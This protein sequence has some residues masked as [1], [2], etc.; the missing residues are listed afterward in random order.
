LI[1]FLPFLLGLLL[2]LG[3]PRLAKVVAEERAP[4]RKR[5][6]L[7]LLG[8]VQEL[9]A[10][11]REPL[12]GNRGVIGRGHADR[13]RIVAAHRRDRDE[14]HPPFGFHD[15]LVA[16]RSDEYARR[17]TW[18]LGQRMLEPSH[19]DVRAAV[20]AVE[21]EGHQRAR[22]GRALRP[23]AGTHANLP[24][25][26]AIGIRRDVGPPGTA[27]RRNDRRRAASGRK[28]HQLHRLT[29]ASRRREVLLPFHARP[30]DRDDPL[31][32]G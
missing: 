3:R 15:R 17:R 9:A 11:S 31:S 20:G 25:E 7:A 12:H 30:A 14:V 2:L 22:G 24:G 21:A 6:R 13:W 23:G 16:I 5:D 26:D 32:V 1:S 27:M 29:A 8:P 4:E 19:A 10:D 28:P 18:I